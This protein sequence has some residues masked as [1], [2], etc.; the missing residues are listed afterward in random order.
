MK[1]VSLIRDKQQE[2]KNF[3]SEI[4]E[5][6]CSFTLHNNSLSNKQETN[7]SKPSSPARQ[8]PSQQQQSLKTP[9]E[10]ALAF[11]EKAKIQIKKQNSIITENGHLNETSPSSI[12]TTTSTT[13]AATTTPTNTKRDGSKGR[14][15]KGN[16]IKPQ[17]LTSELSIEEK[18]IDLND[19]N[20]LPNSLSN[21]LKIHENDEINE[22]I[23]GLLDEKSKSEVNNQTV[24]NESA[25]NSAQII[26]IDKYRI[27]FTNDS[28]TTTTPN[29]VNNEEFQQFDFLS[30]PASANRKPFSSKTLTKSNKSST[31]P[32][33]TTT[34]TTSIA[35]TPVN[36]DS[37]SHH[38]DYVEQINLLKQ[39][40]KNHL[41]TIQ[42][43]QDENNKFK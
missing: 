18:H 33:S 19:I 3:L 29:D 22:N 34:T 20:L 37:G 39:N 36:G 13:T 10:E 14:L 7:K 15:S 6:E 40:E 31:Q 41:E 5:E 35:A 27:D 26:D 24:N 2:I 9:T 12:T 21:S 17:N 38:N 43:L 4:Q 16:E 30:K 1:R 32:T 28:S 25:D 42:Y 23:V 11:I 8:Q